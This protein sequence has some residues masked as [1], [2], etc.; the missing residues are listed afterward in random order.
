MSEFKVGDIIVGKEGNP[1]GYH[2][3]NYERG[4]KGKIVEVFEKQIVVTTLQL[5]F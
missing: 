5:K 1:G 3:T 4:F 2:V